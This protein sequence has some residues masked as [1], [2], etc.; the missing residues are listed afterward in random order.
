MV[1][2]H[3]A[4]RAF[5]VFLV[6]GD[7]LF[8]EEILAILEFL[9]VVVADDVRQTGLFHVALA[10]CQVVETLVALRFLRSLVLRD[11]L[12]KFSGQPAGIHHFVLGVAR[13]HTRAPDGHLGRCRVEILKFQF[14][15][16]AAIHRVG[17]FAAEFTHVEM[18]GTPSDF[19][20]GIEGDADLAVL[21]LLMVAQVAHGLH[22]FGNAGLVVGTEQGGSVGHNQIL[23]HVLQQF[24]EF[25]RTRH[26]AR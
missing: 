11:A 14:A 7:G 19:L 9:A 17:P 15:Q 2:Y 23:A 25:L 8:L 13:M 4:H 22:D 20:V 10:T 3:H 6:H 21:N 18:V 26:N 1:V 5:T 24:R 12:H 16:V